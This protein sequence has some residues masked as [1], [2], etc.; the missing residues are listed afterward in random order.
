MPLPVLTLDN[1][2][3]TLKGSGL[4]SAPD[5]FLRIFSRSPGE[6]KGQFSI[7]INER[8]RICFQWRDGDCHHV[9]IVDYH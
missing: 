2:N 5:G 7:R 9:E 1:T 6:R 3:A 8:W 4:V